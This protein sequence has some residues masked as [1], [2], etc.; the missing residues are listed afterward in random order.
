MLCSGGSEW[1]WGGDSITHVQCEQA[2]R[3][4][5]HYMSTYQSL[6]C[7]CNYK[8]SPFPSA[9]LLQSLGVYIVLNVI[10]LIYSCHAFQ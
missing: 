1:I 9:V 10:V 8:H 4:Y 5:T 6:N 3:H 2:I 7:E